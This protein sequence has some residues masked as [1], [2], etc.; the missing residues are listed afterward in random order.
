MSNLGLLQS[1]LLKVRAVLLVKVVFFQ[2]DHKLTL[3]RQ[4][5]LLNF[6]ARTLDLLGFCHDYISCLK[7]FFS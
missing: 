5:Q 6:H 3:H 1:L 7:K 2:Q 4:I